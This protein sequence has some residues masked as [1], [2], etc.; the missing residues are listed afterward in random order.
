MAFDE[1]VIELNGPEIAEIFRWYD[2]VKKKRLPASS[3]E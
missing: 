2:Q 1:R 3:R